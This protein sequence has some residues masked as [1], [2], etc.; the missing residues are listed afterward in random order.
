ME[1]SPYSKKLKYYYGLFD[2]ESIPLNIGRKF[3]ESQNLL[4]KNGEIK[5]IDVTDKRSFNSAKK[6]VDWIN[7]RDFKYGAKLS[8]LYNAKKNGRIEWKITLVYLPSKDPT[9]GFA[10]DEHSISKKME[11]NGTVSDFMK[12]LS[13]ESREGFRKGLKKGLFKTKCK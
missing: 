10:E 5:L 9:L 12:Q 6:W 7:E 8:R 4:N 2:Q 11:L 1:V 13:K 3:Y